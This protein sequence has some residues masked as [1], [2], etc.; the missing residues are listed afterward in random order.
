MQALD[1]PVNV[2]LLSSH[3]KVF[4][5]YTIHNNNSQQTNKSDM[6]KKIYI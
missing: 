5:V 3:L 6:V 4:Q 2:S 1:P